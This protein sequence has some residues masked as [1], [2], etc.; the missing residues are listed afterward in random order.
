MDLNPG[1]T[2]GQRLERA[3]LESDRLA[4]SHIQYLAYCVY[5]HALRN[6]LQ[7]HM[8][9]AQPLSAAALLEHAAVDLVSM[10]Q[11]SITDE[12][13]EY[14]VFPWPILLRLYGSTQP[15][16]ETPKVLHAHF[17]MLRLLAAADIT[18]EAAGGD[19]VQQRQDWQDR[20]DRL[21][22]ALGKCC[23]LLDCSFH[24]TRLA[25]YYKSWVLLEKE[26][27]T[28][29]PLP[30][31]DPQLQEELESLD[32]DSSGVYSDEEE[33]DDRRP[34][35]K[36]HTARVLLSI[37]DREDFSMMAPLVKRTLST[38]RTLSPSMQCRLV[39][40]TITDGA[41]RVALYKT[42]L[43]RS[44]AAADL[45]DQAV[46]TDP[47]F[48][49]ALLHQPII[50]KHLLKSMINPM[51]APPA[52]FARV[53]LHFLASPVTHSDHPLWK[54]L[55]GILCKM[56]KAAYAVPS[57]WGNTHG[58]HLASLGMDIDYVPQHVTQQALQ[59]A[60]DQVSSIGAAIVETASEQAGP[61]RACQ[62]APDS[63]SREASPVACP[64]CELLQVPKAIAASHTHHK[65]NYCVHVL[66]AMVP[67]AVDV[68]R[69]RS[70]VSGL[71]E[72]HEFTAALLQTRP[73]HQP[74]WLSVLWRKPPK[75]SVLDSP[76]T[77]AAGGEESKQESLRPGRPT[78]HRDCEEDMLNFHVAMTDEFFGEAPRGTA[79]AALDDALD[80]LSR[81]SLFGGHLSTPMDLLAS[82]AQ[83]PRDLLRA[84]TTAPPS[85]LSGLAK[86]AAM[87]A[88]ECEDAVA[89]IR[90]HG[91]ALA[92]CLSPMRPERYRNMVLMDAICVTRGA[93]LRELFVAWTLNSASLPF[94]TQHI[95]TLKQVAEDLLGPDASVI[96]ETFV[97]VPAI[98]GAGSLPATPEDAAS[99]D[100]LSQ[101][102]VAPLSKDYAMYREAVACDSGMP[103]HFPHHVLKVRRSWPFFVLRR[104]HTT[105]GV[106]FRT[107]LQGP[108]GTLQGMFRFLRSRKSIMDK[109]STHLKLLGVAILCGIVRR[110]CSPAEQA[111]FLDLVWEHLQE[112]HVLQH[113]WESALTVKTLS[114]E[115]WYLMCVMHAVAFLPW[116]IQTDRAMAVFES[117]G[118]P[119]GDILTLAIA[120]LAGTPTAREWA[121]SCMD[122]FASLKLETH[123]NARSFSVTPLRTR[124]LE[125]MLSQTHYREY[126]EELLQCIASPPLDVLT[127]FVSAL[128]DMDILLNMQAGGNNR[129]FIALHYATAHRVLKYA[130]TA[131]HRQAGLA[132]I[133]RVHGS[134]AFVET[135]VILALLIEHLTYAQ[136]GNAL[137]PTE[138]ATPLLAV[139]GAEAAVIDAMVFEPWTQSTMSFHEFLLRLAFKLDLL[140]TTAEEIL[141]ME[142]ASKTVLHHESSVVLSM[143]VDSKLSQ[144][145]FQQVLEAL[146]GALT[147]ALGSCID[148]EKQL[149]T[150]M[151]RRIRL[152]WPVLLSRVT[153]T[154]S[155]PASSRLSKAL[156]EA[157]ALIQR[158]LPLMHDVE[159]T[160]TVSV[161]PLDSHRSSQERKDNA[162][163]AAEPVFEHLLLPGTPEQ[164][165]TS[166]EIE[167][168]TRRYTR[169]GEFQARMQ[170]LVEAQRQATSRDLREQALLRQSDVMEVMC[171]EDRAACTRAI[172]TWTIALDKLMLL[173]SQTMRLLAHV[174]W[175]PSMVLTMTA[176]HASRI[177]SVV[178]DLTRAWH[179]F[180]RDQ[181]LAL[182]GRGGAI[183]TA[184]GPEKLQRIVDA[185]ADISVNAVTIAGQYISRLKP[186]PHSMKAF[187]A[188]SAWL[189]P[190]FEV[191]MQQGTVGKR[192]DAARQSLKNQ[193]YEP[194]AALQGS[195]VREFLLGGL[196][197]LDKLRPS[198]DATTPSDVAVLLGRLLHASRDL[199]WRDAVKDAL[200]NMR[201]LVDDRLSKA[202]HDVQRILEFSPH[203]IARLKGFVR[204]E[205]NLTC[206]CA[207]FEAAAAAA[208]SLPLPP[209]Q[210]RQQEQGVPPR[211]TLSYRAYVTRV[212]Q[213]QA[214]SAP[215]RRR[216]PVAT[217]WT[218]MEFRDALLKCHH[219]AAAQQ[220]SKEDALAPHA[221][222]AE[223]DPD[224]FDGFPALHAIAM[225]LRDIVTYSIPCDIVVLPTSDD[226]R[227]TTAAMAHDTAASLMNSSAS[228]SRPARCP[229][230]RRNIPRG[231]KP[232][233]DFT[234]TRI[235]GILAEFHQ[236]YL[237]SSSGDHGSS[238]A[239][240]TRDPGIDI[241]ESL[242]ATS[243]D[244]SPALASLEESLF[245]LLLLAPRKGAIIQHLLQQPTLGKD[246][247]QEALFFNLVLAGLSSPHAAAVEVITVL[248]NALFGETQDAQ[249][250]AVE[251]TLSTWEDL[252]RSQALVFQS[253]GFQ[254]VSPAAWLRRLWRAA[255]SYKAAKRLLDATLHR[256]PLE[257]LR[258]AAETAAGP[259][260]PLQALHAE[261]QSRPCVP[262][263]KSSPR[264]ASLLVKLR[265]C[266]D[267]KAPPL[268]HWLNGP[269]VCW[270]EL[271]QDR[272]SLTGVLCRERVRWIRRVGSQVAFVQTW[273]QNSSMSLFVATP[274]TLAD[275]AWA[276]Q[277][278]RT[279]AEETKEEDSAEEPDIRLTP[280]FTGAWTQ[281]VVLSFVDQTKGPLTRLHPPEWQNLKPPGADVSEPQ[282]VLADSQLHVV[283]QCAV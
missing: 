43:S 7:V 267:D 72:P 4:E 198:T 110:P 40:H 117:G 184:A 129:D 28:R 233:R 98:V 160:H 258:V 222:Q 19:A 115:F 275:A 171:K 119:R 246:L 84:M 56:K 90:E 190:M 32:S 76:A 193:C 85:K 142:R 195:Q 225:E 228:S 273:P 249:E 20:Q 107:P 25:P 237:S 57:L 11:Q 83:Y 266:N 124:S 149:P 251:R 147:R 203:A 242:L 65:G 254:H 78:E 42:I 46:L 47:A 31:T 89:L 9:A 15:T 256:A 183:V 125:W 111:L 177:T 214:R 26:V 159:T 201:R 282:P 131:Q 17:Q 272:E 133:A 134:N 185:A 109:P 33:D 106:L 245:G 13:F 67:P 174:I 118:V 29:K 132:S 208:Q 97:N 82:L 99:I 74:W 45:E 12:M 232:M 166:A 135:G 192:I 37:K 80:H 23:R 75:A 86:L 116:P 34:S 61:L 50:P 280:L 35:V 2:A 269:Y 10:L 178:Q 227:W 252:S 63:A 216:L 172:R 176:E 143:H 73:G 157:E 187:E 94:L 189:L 163:A 268:P 55:M 213:R 54:S 141:A 279:P 93:C 243:R 62:L 277:F 276:A 197:C 196:Q 103:A 173:H 112:H 121:N 105:S 229:L 39:N 122:S 16:T 210:Q 194:V 137:P 21:H 114:S 120:M 38:L 22:A 234:L 260:W 186:E 215:N 202:L 140:V 123:F 212:M 205:L 158:E 71:P 168:E 127:A 6:W 278:Q 239:G 207:P 88:L 79:Q 223:L 170:S 58:L 191:A 52:V 51:S 231:A 8:N 64:V 218:S 104:A 188:Q 219:T 100:Q 274:E 230:T 130:I 77:R 153:A 14:C 18:G 53:L 165:P 241:V 175:N 70:T 145:Q 236:K 257:W 250:A 271:P 259:F 151:Q 144:E 244:S 91:D 108:L 59:E 152:L 126:W 69:R 255:P 30:A 200:F 156:T 240:A 238:S 36:R 262:K 217:P 96:A 138:A 162:T 247:S 161:G 209:T 60:L 146:A 283:V 167:A 199:G 136:A 41:E 49:E 164:V 181:G 154:V 150:D 92:T 221:A 155:G 211:E 81:A 102:G 44:V 226:A 87:R 101:H 113:M 128:F 48:V 235:R 224:D 68:V 270:K 179:S 261:L 24:H 95:I 206:L 3:M 169:M 253:A 66:A 1:S 139:P 264:K 281:R 248:M 263:P 220:D 5:A 27:H 180:P 182:L 148:S 265:A 204:E